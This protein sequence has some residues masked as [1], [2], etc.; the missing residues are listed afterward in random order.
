MSTLNL[1]SNLLEIPTDAHMQ[2]T[3]SNFD[4]LFITQSW[5]LQDDWLILDD[6]ENTTLHLD[7]PDSIAYIHILYYITLSDDLKCISSKEGLSKVPDE[8]L[9]VKKPTIS[10]GLSRNARML[11]EDIENFYKENPSRNTVSKAEGFV[12]LSHLFILQLDL[13]LEGTVLIKPFCQ[14]TGI[15]AHS[16]QRPQKAI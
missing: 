3:G 5:V 12:L 7:Q 13:S 9:I 14:S 11:F 2:A 4:W 10:A 6:N 16:T 1:S 8:S 15:H